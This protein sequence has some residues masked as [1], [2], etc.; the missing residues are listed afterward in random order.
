MEKIF[1]YILMPLLIGCA[2]VTTKGTLDPISMPFTTN[3]KSSVTFRFYE[4]NENTAFK[5]KAIRG[6]QRLEDLLRISLEKSGLFT[7]IKSFPD[8]IYFQAHYKEPGDSG[9]LDC[10][11]IEARIE[12]ELQLHWPAKTDYFLDVYSFSAQDTYHSPYMHWA[13][14][15]AVT[16]GLIPLRIPQENDFRFILYDKLGKPLLT[17]SVIGKYAV[18]SWT[19]LFFFNGFHM[20]KPIPDVQSEGDEAFFHHIVQ[21]VSA[22]IK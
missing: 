14:L 5:F 22:S 21:K 13:M 8:K 9:H 16:L 7:E 3:K 6:D 2:S 17:G 19:P 20:F 12:E 15:H 18:W 1:L 10:N 11:E 4:R